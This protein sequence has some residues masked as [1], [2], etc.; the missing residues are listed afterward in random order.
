VCTYIMESNSVYPI[1]DL[2]LHFEKKIIIITILCKNCWIPQCMYTL[3]VP[4]YS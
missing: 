4:P 3:T 2:K 1:L